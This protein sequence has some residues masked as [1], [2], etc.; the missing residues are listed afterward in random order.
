VS[1]VLEVAASE[2]GAVVDHDDIGIAALAGDVVEH[3]SDA[4]PR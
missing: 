1:P 4:A 3:Q 2:F